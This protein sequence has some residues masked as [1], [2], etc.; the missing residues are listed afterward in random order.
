M[1]ENSLLEKVCGDWSSREPRTVD[2]LLEEYHSVPSAGSENMRF[3]FF[4]N[5]LD[6]CD[7]EEA[8][9]IDA[10][11][12]LASMHGF[13]ICAAVSMLFGESRWTYPVAMPL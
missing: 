13:N 8:S 7:G 1:H 9:V 11:N 12:R 4:I 5:G 3:C 10:V 6:E 2:E